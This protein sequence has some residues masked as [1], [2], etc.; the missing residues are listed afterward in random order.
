MCI[1][2]YYSFLNFKLPIQL[3][4]AISTERERRLG[5]KD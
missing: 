2:L 5:V 3:P 1:Q 4:N